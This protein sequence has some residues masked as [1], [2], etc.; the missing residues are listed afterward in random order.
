VVNSQLMTALLKPKNN[1]S[2]TFGVPNALRSFDENSISDG[3]FAFIDYLAIDHKLSLII[4]T[5]NAS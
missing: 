2:I 1:F 3:N 4:I 5:L